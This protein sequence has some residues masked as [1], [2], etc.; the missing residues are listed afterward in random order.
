MSL[1]RDDRA[2]IKNPESTE[3][4]STQ[5]SGIKS[6]FVEPPFRE[7]GSQVSVIVGSNISMLLM[8]LTVTAALLSKT[9]QNYVLGVN[10]NGSCSIFDGCWV[11]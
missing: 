7:N 10:C 4:E 11:A 5:S 1:L 9:R 2:G 6:E 8:G 3:G